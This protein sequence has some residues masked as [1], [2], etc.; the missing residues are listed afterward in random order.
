MMNFITQL[1]EEVEQKLREI[2][3]GDNKLRL[4]LR[5]LEL[6]ED[7]F[8]RLKTYIS[9]YNFL[10]EEEEIHFFKEIKP[11]FFCNLIYYQKIYNIEMNRPMSCREAQIEYLKR[12]LDAIQDYADKRLDFYRYYRA[13]S[14]HLDSYYFTRKHSNHEEQYR[15]CFYYERD[16]I[17]ST[18]CDFKVAKLLANDMLQVY[19]LEEIDLIHRHCNSLDPSGI[20]LSNIPRWT[21]KK[22]GLIEIIYALDTLCSV[23]GGN[24][25]LKEL[26]LHF[27]QNFGLNLG[28]ISK[29]LAEMR[30]RQNPTQFIDMMKD[31]LISR[32]NKGEENS[33]LRAC[34]R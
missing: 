18:S 21:D 24:I 26:Q 12:E 31:A 15:D 19:L 23:E 4:S 8:I 17:F 6:F 1:K 5:G 22:T 29:A 16:P 3:T 2:E 10:T 28:N 27:E 32:M 9:R 25:S 20:N 33:I 34:K 7:A 30:L 11:R 14:S 13:G